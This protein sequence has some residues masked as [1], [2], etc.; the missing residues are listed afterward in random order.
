MPG[1]LIIEAMAQVGGILLMGLVDD[2]QTK[3]VYFISLDNVRFRRP[4]R[5][6]DQLRFECEVTQMRGATCK[7][8]GVAL[9][10]GDIAA[11]A[12]MGAMVRDK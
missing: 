2:P 8:H 10:N 7:M 5:P 6:G 3:V 4:V 11:E 12:D 1:V 9:V